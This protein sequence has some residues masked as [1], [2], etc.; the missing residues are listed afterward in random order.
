[1]A[2]LFLLTSC[3]G[4]SNSQNASPLSGNWQI[5]LQRSE[6]NTIKMQTGFFLQSGPSL[7][8]QVVLTQTGCAGVGNAVGQVSGLSV[9]INVSQ[10]GQTVNLTGKSAIDGSNMNGDYS[11]LA[12]GCG[13]TQVGTWTATRVLPLNG[14]FT[15][16]MA[17]QKTPGVLLHFS[18]SVTQG[19]NTGTSTATLSGSM[20]STD[21]PPCFNNVNLSGLVS[22]TSVVLNVL[23]Q[24]G[25]TLGSYQGTGTTDM[26]TITGQYD[27][28][29]VQSDVLGDCGGGDFGTAV[30]TV[31]TASTM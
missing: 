28:F 6:T 8:G 22:G 18:G 25:T 13:T 14:N 26:Q 16:I 20:T 10:T 11:L 4:G 31:Q 15:G 1:V 7:T 19:A 5:S 27:F 30:L 17:S 9:S 29:N 23:A 3:G 21:A 2:L 12:S 24:D